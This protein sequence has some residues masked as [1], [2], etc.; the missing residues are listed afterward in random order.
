MS[1]IIPVVEG[2]GEE[3]A[4]P[5]LIRLWLEHRNFQRY[6][7]VPDL[8]I[9]AKG[10]GKLKAAYDIERHLGIE[11]YIKAALRNQP[12]A[13]LV[14]LDSDGGCS[15]R[16]QGDGLGPQ[17]LARAKAIANNVP[18]AVVV[19]NCEYEAWFL[20]N[21]RSFRDRGIFLRH[22]RIVDELSPESHVGCKGIVAEFI[23]E[24]YEETTHQL[25]LTRRLRFSPAST[26]RSPSYGKLIRDLDRLTKES[27]M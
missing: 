24:I 5:C 10:C 2:F 1:K 14:V 26:R 3:R 18:L 25:E 8:A 16:A 4:V 27:R 12:D 13:I 6:F 11:H 20:A 9:N 7:E 22:K 17:L 21:F 19:A 15:N 23:G